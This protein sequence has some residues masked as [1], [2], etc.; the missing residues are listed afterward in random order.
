MKFQKINYNSFLN[1]SILF[2]FVMIFFS[3]CYYTR[4]YYPKN[5]TIDK[6]TGGS[7]VKFFV[8]LAGE[9]RRVVLHADTSAWHLIRIGINESNTAVIAMVG[10]MADTSFGIN[11]GNRQPSGKLSKTEELKFHLLHVYVNNLTPVT[12]TELKIENDNISHFNYYVYDEE[13]HNEFLIV[14]W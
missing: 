8:Q 7:P 9:Q 5:V 10:E 1:K 2:A 13:F 3:G 6:A 14:P 4:Y 12:G 11:T